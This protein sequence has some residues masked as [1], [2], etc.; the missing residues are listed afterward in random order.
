[1][2]CRPEPHTAGAGAGDRSDQRRTRAFRR[3]DDE[4]PSYKEIVLVPRLRSNQSG[5]RA[6]PVADD[7]ARHH[8][9]RFPMIASLEKAPT[10]GGSASARP[11]A[12]VVGAPVL[13]EAGADR[14]LG[15]VAGFLLVA[16]RVYQWLLAP[17]LGPCCRF[18][19]S[20]SRYMATCI[21]RQGVIRG[22]WLG[23]R[24][25]VRCNPFCAGGHDPPPET[26]S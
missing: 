12:G 23:V 9:P 5:R 14:A 20:C 15:L 6:A 1:M 16:I 18:E 8:F 13:A 25:L 22:V 7:R 26:A 24:R 10:I 4:I 21:E 11:A 2:A 19:P 3:R 17:L